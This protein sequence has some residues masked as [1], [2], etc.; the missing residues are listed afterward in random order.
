[1]DIDFTSQEDC[2]SY[3]IIDTLKHLFCVWACCLVQGED[4]NRWDR[5]SGSDGSCE[6]LP[7]GCTRQN[8]FL[9][10]WKPGKWS[11]G[12][13]CQQISWWRRGM[14]GRG[15]AWWRLA[16]AEVRTVSHSTLRVD[17]EGF[18]RGFA[19]G[20]KMAWKSQSGPQQKHLL[21]TLG[22]GTLDHLGGLLCLLLFSFIE[23]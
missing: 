19:V 22:T 4:L 6:G 13:P 15:H 21:S 9:A 17:G 14:E 8:D 12:T 23:V 20:P 18:F 3:K 7:Q 11:G 1:M 16:G 10:R 5:G 2:S